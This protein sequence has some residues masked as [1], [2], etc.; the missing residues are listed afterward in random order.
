[1]EAKGKEWS[2]GFLPC[3]FGALS[4]VQ[5]G[6]AMATASFKDF[7]EQTVRR[8]QLRVAMAGHSDGEAHSHS[9]HSRWKK[10]GAPSYHR[11]AQ[12]QTEYYLLYIHLHAIIRPCSSMLSSNAF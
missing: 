8:R 9:R 5:E 6:A 11:D 1:M 3:Y 12:E 7:D 2:Y 10:A 4:G